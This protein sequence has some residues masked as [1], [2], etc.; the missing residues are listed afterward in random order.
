[1]KHQ[2]TALQQLLNNQLPLVQVT[3][4]LGAPLV[5]HSNRASPPSTIVLLDG[6]C[7]NTGGELLTLSQVAL[8][9]SPATLRRKH[10]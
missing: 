6:P 4:G 2:L 8:D 10:W 3:V 1:M 9:V 7:N 5:W